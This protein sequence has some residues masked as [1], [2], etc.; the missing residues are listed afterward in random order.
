MSHSEPSW[1]STPPEPTPEP[2]RV[3]DLTYTGHSTR[4]VTGP[5]GA[6]G[7]ADDLFA[8][9]LELRGVGHVADDVAVPELLHRAVRR[10]THKVV[11]FVAAAVNEIRRTFGVTDAAELRAEYTARAEK[12]LDAASTPPRAVR[13]RVG[14]VLADTRYLEVSGQ[15]LTLGSALF[16]EFEELESLDRAAA[17]TA[18]FGSEVAAAVALLDEVTFDMRVLK[19]ADSYGDS[20]KVEFVA[21]Y[22]GRRSSPYLCTGGI[23]TP[24]PYSAAQMLLAGGAVIGA[25]IFSDPELEVAAALTA[26]LDI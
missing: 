9:E 3:T 19:T 12:V 16:G 21:A 2:V 13:S 11:P 4:P 1:P 15:T 25:Q 24:G 7:L 6:V 20:S 23:H 26:L 22:N 14:H 5:A 8:V 10:D 17:V 18:A